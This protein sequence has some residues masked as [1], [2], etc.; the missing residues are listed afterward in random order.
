M[1]TTDVLSGYGVQDD[2]I[3]WAAGSSKST[4]STALSQVMDCDE[5]DADEI[6]DAARSRLADAVASAAYGLRI[7]AGDTRDQAE[8]ASDGGEILEWLVGGDL[9]DIAQVAT[10]Q[11]AASRLATEYLAD[12]DWSPRTAK[13]P[14]TLPTLT[15][16][17]CPHT[18]HPRTDEH[19]AICPKCKSPYWDKAR[20]AP[21]A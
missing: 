2:H 13:M 10:L 19:P 6:R 12:E 11:E 5:S 7:D 8:A 17:R 20:K 9:M 1:T 16:L 15:C 14:A 4:I 3:P 21:K 18:W